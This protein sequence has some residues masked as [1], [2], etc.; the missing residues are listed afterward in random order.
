[1]SM[2]PYK[3][4]NITTKPNTKVIFKLIF[5]FRIIKGQISAPLWTNIGHKGWRKD[6]KTFIRC[7]NFAL[8]FWDE[9]NANFVL[10]CF[11]SYSS[12]KMWHLY[13]KYMEKNNNAVHLRQGWSSL[14]FSKT[15][16]IWR[17]ILPLHSKR[18]VHFLFCVFQTKLKKAVNIFCRLPEW[19]RN[20]QMIPGFTTGLGW[21]R[22]WKS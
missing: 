5:K 2:T 9:L 18:I 15:F 8:K 6:R 19:I 12:I 3:L 22:R 4:N 16:S 13:L 20:M 11:S 17:N 7:Y 14:I 1:M 21:Q 10:L